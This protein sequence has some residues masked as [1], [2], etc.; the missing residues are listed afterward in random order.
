MTYRVH[1]SELF[2][3]SQTVFCTEWFHA[4][5]PRPVISTNFTPH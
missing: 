1:I 5:L 4:S 3:V 2:T